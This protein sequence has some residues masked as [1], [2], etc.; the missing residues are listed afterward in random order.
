MGW[1]W[2]E[3]F[4]STPLPS[5]TPISLFQFIGVTEQK[6]RR[7]LQYFAAVAAGMCSRYCRRCHGRR[8]HCVLVIAG[9]DESKRASARDDRLYFY[10]HFLFEVVSE[11]DK[12][13]GPCGHQV[14]SRLCLNVD[15]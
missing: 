14:T 2:A 11:E 13:C 12:G 5:L 10:L 4:H 15:M 9:S 6:M 7:Q 3:L 8:P 1:E